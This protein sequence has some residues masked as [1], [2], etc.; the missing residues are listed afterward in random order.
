MFAYLRASKTGSLN[1][2]KKLKIYLILLHYILEHGIIVS[3]NKYYGP[4][5]ISKS[6]S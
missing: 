2:L 6:S 1:F 3:N 4:T 5:V